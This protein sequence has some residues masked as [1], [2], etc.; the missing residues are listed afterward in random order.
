M[1]RKKY[2]FS[3]T[4]IFI[5]VVYTISASLLYRQSIRLDEAQSLWIATKP[6]SALL[7]A[8]AE[9]VHVPLYGLLLHFW[10]QLLGTSIIVARTLSLLFFVLTLPVLYKLVKEVSTKGVA[11]LT[12][13]LFSLS[14]FIMWYTSEARMYTLFT[15]TTSLN[16]LYFLRL[17]RSNGDKG[18]MGFFVSAILGLYTHYFF[19]FLIATQGVY[20]L[21]RA[22]SR[23]TKEQ[24]Q[25]NKWSAVWQATDLVRVYIGILSGAM[26]L[27]IPWVAFFLSKGGGGSMQPLIPPPTSFNIFQT[28]VNF[29]FGFQKQGVQAVLISLWPLI[30]ILLFFVFTRKKRQ[31]TASIDYFVLATFLP[32]IFVFFISYVRPIFLSRYLI[33]VTP[34]LFFLLSWTLL[35]YSRRVSTYLVMGF[36]AVMVSLM[37]YQNVSAATPVKEDYQGVASYLTQEATPRDIIAVTAPFTIYPIE[38]SYNGLTRIDTIPLWNRY[39]TGPIPQYNLESFKAQLETYKLQYAR[40]FVVFSYDQG[41]EAKIKDYLEKNYKREAMRRFSPGIEVRVYK[42]RYDIP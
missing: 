35:N 2:L 4:I 34:T 26:A 3:L 33:L 30:V 8:T 41:Y 28:I 21:A 42:L 11:L 15:F 37:F 38:Y 27:F 9:D 10:T 7:A 19:I 14:P 6:V 25:L 18:K 29:I 16:H 5:S 36:L 23:F 40:M 1:F 12:V 31:V 13:T 39:I 24:M 17:Y 20:L 22:F 32:I